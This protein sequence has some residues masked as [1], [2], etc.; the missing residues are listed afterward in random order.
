MATAIGTARLA[1]SR[2][3]LA[4][5]LSS[6]ADL[7]GRLSGL[8]D[9]LSIAAAIVE[10][11][12]RLIEHDTIRVY[13]VDHGD[14]RCASRSPSRARSSDAPSRPG[15]AAHADRPGPDGLGRR[16]TAG[17]CG[18][19]TRRPTRASWSSAT[20][21]PE[22]MLIVPMVQE[23]VVRGVIVVSAIGTG[24]FDSDDEVTLT[25][26]AV[27]RGPGADQRR[28]RRIDCGASR[29]SWSSSSKASAAS[30]TSTSA[31]SSTLDP[32]RRPGADRRLAEGASSR[33]TR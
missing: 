7:A 32:A 29:T 5:R 12:K 2:R 22:S 4:D 3:G 9:R 33:T 30:S 17:R 26:F 18:S 8:H 28:E 11:A 19:T 27:G 10:E 1:D 21:R 15:H 13:R 23:E 14:R 31:C 20:S 16:S 6:I 24:R 25:I